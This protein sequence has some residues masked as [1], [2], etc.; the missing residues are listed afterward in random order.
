MSGM[1]NVRAAVRLGAATDATVAAGTLTEDSGA[2]GI[3]A[4]DAMPEPP[5]L[6]QPISEAAIMAELIA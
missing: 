4:F 2:A 3:A 6:L 5:E 1:V